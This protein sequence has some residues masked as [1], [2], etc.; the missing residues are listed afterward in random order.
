MN[1]QCIAVISKKDSQPIRFIES[2]EYNDTIPLVAEI[3]VDRKQLENKVNSLLHNKHREITKLCYSILNKYHIV[4]HK[5]TFPVAIPVA[6][7]ILDFLTTKEQADTRQIS[8]YFRDL[9]K[10]KSYT[11]LVNT[12]NNLVGEIGLPE[13]ALAKH[14]N[15]IKIYIDDADYINLL[16][17][18]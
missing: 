12:F 13:Q 2:N 18:K 16:A 4:I 1:R 3:Y 14:E 8:K 7:N 11:Q 6:S 10:S 17:I 15:T 9:P 5:Q